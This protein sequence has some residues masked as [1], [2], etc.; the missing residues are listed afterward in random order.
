MAL[1]TSPD[2]GYPSQPPPPM[3]KSGGGS[4][5]WVLW[6]CGGCLT[7][8]VILGV[9]VFG[10]VFFVFGTIKRTDVVAN[11]IKQAQSSPKVQAALGTPI[12]TGWWISGSVNINNGSGRADIS[13]PIEGPKGDATL[14]LK[15]TKP[16]G[17]N[18]DYTVMEVHV[19]GGET[20]NLLEGN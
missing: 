3:P 8:L 7:L 11:G 19:T 15:A 10:I 5:K 17:G 2:S 1:P 9:F 18:W 16:A 14:I 6:G 4:K 13:G 12:E 20:I